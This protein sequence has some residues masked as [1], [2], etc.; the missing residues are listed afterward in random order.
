M[1]GG[2]SLTVFDSNGQT[3]FTADDSEVSAQEDAAN[4]DLVAAAPE[5]YAA[6]DAIV[7]G[8]TGS[9]LSER[10]IQARLERGRARFDAARAALKK[11]R[12][13]A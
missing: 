7:T 10:D 1:S 2:E 4:L 5:L 12:G 13:E 11:A 6:L 8:E 3:L 9:M